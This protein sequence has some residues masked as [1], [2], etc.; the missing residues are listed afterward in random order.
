MTSLKTTPLTTWHEDHGARMVPFAG[1]TMPV[2][3][4]GVLAEHAAVR[5]RVGLFDIT[6][7]GEV[8]VGGP[9]AEQWISGLITNRIDGIAPGK[10]VY[11]T[12]CNE[13]GGCLDDMLVY[14]LDGER[15]LIV[16]NAA[17]HAKIAAWLRSHLPPRG[18]TLDDASDRTGLIAVQGPDSRELMGRLGQLR[19]AAAA[20]AALEFYTHFRSA[21]PGGEWIVSRTGYT[22][23][24]GYEL[25][26][27]VSDMLPVWQELVAKGGDLGVAPIGLAARD[28]LRF[29]AGYCLYGHE[30]SEDWTPLEAGVGWAVK[31][32]KPGGFIGSEAL[33]ALKA[34]GLP[35]RLLGL[36]VL[37]GPLARE[38]SPVLAGERKVGHVTSGTFAPTLARKLAI[39]LV[40]AAYA[41]ADLTVDVRGK[42]LATRPVAL[43]FLAAR[44][45]GDPR[46]ERTQSW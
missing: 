35:R 10:V 26:L 11:T 45:K 31:L 2:Q 18:V 42:R 24:H 14:R 6:H 8:Y 20:I 44:V 43:P 19:S 23:E 33:A 12:M 41:E 5:E 37:G 32:K 36:E 7:M 30:L 25:Y 4:E 28:T 40:D 46:A 1:Y 13:R 17:N 27:P 3:Y 34:A 9:D 29:E 16:M 22:G 15:W 38:G 39:A 21:G